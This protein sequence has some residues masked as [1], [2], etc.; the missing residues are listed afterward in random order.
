[1]KLIIGL[2][3]PE[4][5]YQHTRHNFGFLSLN[6]LSKKNNLTWKKHKTSN[7]LI[8]N[9]KYNKEKIILAKPQTFMNNSGSAAKLLKQYYKLPTNKIIVIYDDLDLPFNK[10]KISKSKSSGGHK[11][12]DSIIQYLKSKE[13]IRMRLG[14]GPKKDNAESFVLGKFNEEQTKK[15][16]E[17]IDTSH[18]ALE[19]ILA[20]GY[21]SASNKYN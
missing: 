21:D 13:F 18:L 7:S 4:K 12:V 8:T 3:N 5:K 17:I 19:E 15:L 1:M 9:F 11:G 14:I 2:G 16:P 20:E 6:S 10:L